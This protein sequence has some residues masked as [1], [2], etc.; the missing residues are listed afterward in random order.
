MVSRDVDPLF[1]SHTDSQKCSCDLALSPNIK[2]YNSIKT[3]YSKKE[4]PKK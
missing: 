3:G 4:L 2:P 1:S